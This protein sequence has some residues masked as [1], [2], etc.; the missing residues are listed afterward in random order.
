MNTSLVCTGSTRMR[1]SA[2][3]GNPMV[4][5]KMSDAAMPA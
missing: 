1:V 5:I 3:C 4:L 2:A